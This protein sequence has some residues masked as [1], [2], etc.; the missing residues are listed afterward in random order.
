MIWC[1]LLSMRIIHCLLTSVV[2][3]GM[4]DRDVRYQRV[5]VYTLND[6]YSTAVFLIECV[7]QRPNPKFRT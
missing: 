5:S 3:H 7:Y 6:W 2:A 4:S 1:M